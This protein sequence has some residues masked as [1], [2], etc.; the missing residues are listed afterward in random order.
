M[1]KLGKT[2]QS[3]DVKNGHHGSNV[4]VNTKHDSSIKHVIGTANYVDDIA[5]PRG[6]LFVATGLSTMAHARILSLDLDS[7]KNS[8]GVVDV[9]VHDDIPGDP[10]VSPVYTGDLLLAKDLVSYVGQ[11]LFAVAATTQR[12]AQQAVRKAVVEYEQL[13]AVLTSKAA[14]K[15]SSFVLP[16]R[17]FFMGDADAQMNAA[18]N[19]LEGEQ[20]VR[21]QEHFYLEGQVALVI[22]LEDGGV[23]VHASSQHPSEVQKLVASVLGVNLNQV[24]TEVRRMGGG[25]GGKESQA[26]IPGC[27]A[28]VFAIRNNCAVKY[29]MPRHDDMVQTGKRHDFWN[30]YRCGFDDAGRLLGVDMELAG[31]CGFSA[32]LSEGIVDRAMFHADNAYYLNAARIVGYRCKTNTVSN[33]AFRGFGGPKGMMAVEA[34]MEDVALSLGKDPLDVRKV[35]L[36]APGRDETPYGQK[37]E[38]HI[39]RTLIDQLEA[40]SDYRAR[41][42]SIVAFNKAANEKS[43]PLLK[44]ISLTPVKFGISF[45]STHLNQAGA[46]MHV[47]TDGSIQINHGG[48]E[49]GQGLHTKI[50][51]IVAQT[52]GIDYARITVTSTRTDKVPNTSPTAASSGTDMNGMAAQDA[53]TQIRDRLTVFLADHFNTEPVNIHFANDCINVAGASHAFADMVQ[54]A[55]MNR[56]QLSA[57]GFYKTPDVH[58]DKQ[59]GKGHPFYYYACGAAV[60]EVLVDRMTGEY[61]VTQVDILHDVGDSINP[62]ID[63]GQ[64]EGGFVQGMGWLTTEELLWD[65]TGRLISN[66]PANYKIPTAYDVPENFN[67]ELFAAQN[68]K[69]TIYRSKAVG[70]PPLMLAISVWCAL[71]D[72]CAASADYKIAPKL[73]SPATFEQ[74]YWAIDELQDQLRQKQS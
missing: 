2:S 28:A 20:M 72:A 55:Y 17:T 8:K 29:R 36:Y 34:M 14:L 44:G 46:L 37:V 52:L 35:N 6:M 11:P 9:I 21:G 57:T 18:P 19:K 7:V 60:S 74:V 61:K 42:E 58:F 43:S 45:T 69:P 49:M 23:H 71:R 73:N 25:F 22:P 33:T 32:D 13:E 59:A 16:T 39:L 27:M 31:L 15:Q 40:S 48:T 4:G 3:D 26:A 70:E 68:H 47:Y 56:V 62:A 64:I 30:R 12:L 66:S 54:L 10:D 24:Q 67:V 1:R 65:D 38:Q 50:A 5:E 53:A 51:Q 63:I 41:R